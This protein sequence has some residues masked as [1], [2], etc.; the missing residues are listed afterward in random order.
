MCPFSNQSLCYDTSLCGDDVS[1]CAGVIFSRCDGQ[2]DIT[3]CQLVTS[4][5]EPPIPI[6]ISAFCTAYSLVGQET[7]PSGDD[8]VNQP[9]SAGEVKAPDAEDCR[10]CVCT[11][12]GKWT[13]DSG[14]CEDDVAIEG[15]SGEDGGLGTLGMVGGGLVIV[16]LLIAI[17]YLEKNRSEDEEDENEIGAEEKLGLDFTSEVDD[18]IQVSGVGSASD[19]EVISVP[20]LPPIGPP[21]SSEE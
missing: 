19:K 17:L 15:K 6:E 4:I 21:P 3:D 20:E 2:V 11:T 9:C 13:C 5:C 16:G 8:W 10:Y 14:Q 7:N 12:A 1:A 18:N